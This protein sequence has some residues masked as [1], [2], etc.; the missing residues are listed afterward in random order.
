L[1]VLTW[2]WTQE[3]MLYLYNEIL[4]YS[5]SG[6]AMAQL[7]EARESSRFDSRW[8]HWNYSLLHPLTQTLTEM[9][10]RSICW[11]EGSPCVELTTLSPSCADCLEVLG[12]STSWIPKDQSR[13]FLGWLYPLAFYTK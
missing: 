8:G 1:I 9:S 2:R 13:P 7:D 5:F 10:T 6:Y 4:L 12:A 3:I 11:G